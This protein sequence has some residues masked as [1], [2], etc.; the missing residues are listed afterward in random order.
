MRVHHLAQIREHR[1]GNAAPNISIPNPT[2]T[3][4]ADRKLQKLLRLVP[5]RYS[6][7]VFVAVGIHCDYH[8]K[9]MIS[10]PL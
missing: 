5:I 10:G 8:V 6:S 2:Q 3:L 4:R 7:E 9:P 1:E